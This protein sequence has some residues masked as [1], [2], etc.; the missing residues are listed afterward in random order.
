MSL[1]AKRGG[2]N[3]AMLESG[4]Y[5]AVCVGLIDIG[6]QY[7]E[8]WDKVTPKVILEWEVI[9]ETHI[10]DG[11]EVNKTI[12]ARY[13][14]GLGEKNKL[15]KELISWRGRDFTD[16][17]FRGFDLKNILGAPCMLTVKVSERNGKTYSDVVGVSKMMKGMHVEATRP[18]IYFDVD[19][20]PLEMIDKFPQWIQELIINSEEYKERTAGSGNDAGLEYDEQTKFTEDLGEADGQ[21][22]F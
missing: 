10:E 20:S 16:E 5:P 3:K 9:G 1:I 6:R 17:E 11:K 4:T 21:L 15:Y 13:T 8:R 22:P 18:L 2:G 19:E 14:N 12:T 7:E